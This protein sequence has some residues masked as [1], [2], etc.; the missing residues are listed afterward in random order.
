MRPQAKQAQNDLEEVAGLQK[1]MYN[2][3]G[4]AIVATSNQPT[5]TEFELLVAAVDVLALK[6]DFL[7]ELKVGN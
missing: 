6:A 4:E 5:T 2:E 3:L 1:S 7:K